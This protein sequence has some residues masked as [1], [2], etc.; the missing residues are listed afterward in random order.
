MLKKRQ[1]GDGI[2]FT[3]ACQFGCTSLVSSSQIQSN[4]QV[5]KDVGFAESFRH[6]IYRSNVQ[7][8][9]Y[10]VAEN[11]VNDMNT[12]IDSLQHVR[13]RIY[14]IALLKAE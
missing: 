9:A 6:S 5:F 8:V 10:K 12:S 4:Q 7:D 14:R 2:V 11:C 1:S 13:W 3:A